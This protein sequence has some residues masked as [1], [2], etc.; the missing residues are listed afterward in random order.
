MVFGSL[1]PLSLFMFV[2]RFADAFGSYNNKKFKLLFFA[3]DF[4]SIYYGLE[5]GI[6]NTLVLN[7]ISNLDVKEHGK[8]LNKVHILFY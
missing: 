7:F 6:R 8:I 5:V 3:S 1:A 2:H 4:F